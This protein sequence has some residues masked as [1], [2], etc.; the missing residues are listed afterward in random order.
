M[1]CAVVGGGAI[2]AAIAYRLA[3]LGQEVTLLEAATLGAQASGAALGV[4]LAAGSSKLTGAGAA[5][6]LA[7]LSLWDAWLPEIEGR[8]GLAVPYNRR[9]VWR[10]Y[11]T[12]PDALAQQKLEQTIAQRQAEGWELRWV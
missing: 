10:L 2:G 5:L 4:L 6:R 8:S 12:A 7:S 11:D 1:R 3:L 9:G